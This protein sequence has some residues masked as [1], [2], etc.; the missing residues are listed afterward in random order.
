MSGRG[1]GGGNRAKQPPRTRVDGD[2]GVRPVGEG[3]EGLAPALAPDLE[4]VE[5]PFHAL[6]PALVVELPGAIHGNADRRTRIGP[7]R[8]H[9]ATV[10]RR[11]EDEPTGCVSRVLDVHGRDLGWPGGG[12]NRKGVIDSSLALAQRGL[13]RDDR[14]GGWHAGRGLGYRNRA[15]G[16]PCRSRRRLRAGAA[17]G[18][19]RE[20]EADEDWTHQGGS[21]RCAG[22]VCPV[23]TMA[24]T[25]RF[26][27]GLGGRLVANRRFA[28]KIAP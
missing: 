19:S 21:I 22:P 11:D 6:I 16:N 24:L 25:E 15:N 1:R 10:V 23:C 12:R 2:G 4:E 7:R 3:N 14:G 9:E 8:L 5:R 28:A 13:R 27:Q 18:E 26:H 17:A 20:G